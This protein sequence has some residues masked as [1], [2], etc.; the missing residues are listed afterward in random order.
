MRKFII[1]LA[2]V[3]AV[4]VAA[5]LAA[6]RLIDLTP[7]KHRVAERAAA[8]AGRDIT[9][10]GDLRFSLIPTTGAVA[11]DVRVATIDGGEN[12][13][14]RVKAV[15]VQ[16]AFWPLLAG[17]IDVRRITLDGPVAHLEILPDG[18]RSWD[19]QPRVRA[20]DPEAPA[21]DT[22]SAANTPRPSVG[23]TPSIHVGAVEIED[24][25]VVL[26]DRRSGTSERVEEIRAT[27]RSESA[28]GPIASRGQ[29][30]AR[31]VRATY[32]LAIGGFASEAP[33][34]VDLVLAADEGALR[35]ELRGEVE[36]MRS[37][38]RF[39]GHVEVEGDLLVTALQMVTSAAMPGFLAQ[40]FSL[41][42]P[43]EASTT[44]VSA[45]P[46][47]LRF[48]ETSG[49][50]AL[51]VTSGEKPAATLRMALGRIDLDAWLAMPMTNPAI[52]PATAAGP[53]ATAPSE[54]GGAP[55]VASTLGAG[56]GKATNGSGMTAELIL[57]AEAIAYRQGVIAQP[58]VEAR[59]ADGEVQV[60]SLSAKLPGGG[61]LDLSGTLATNVAPPRFRGDVRAEAADLRALLLWLG[62]DPG[63]VPAGHLRALSLKGSIAAEPDSVEMRVLE[64][65]LDGSRITG[66]LSAS[67]HPSPRLFADLAV[68]RL[69]LDPY[70][71]SFPSGREQRTATA[72]SPLSTTP[73]ASPETASGAGVP[74]DSQADALAANVKLLLGTVLFQGETARDVMIDGALGNGSI[75]L[76]EV[77]VA[78]FAGASASAAGRLLAGETTPTLQDLDLR[79]SVADAHR[80]AR[81][82]GSALPGDARALGA[83]DGAVTLNGPT[84]AL[85]IRGSVRAAAAS[86]A[87]DGRIDPLAPRYQG[88][89][90]VNTADLP[91]LLRVA[92]ID[93][94]PRGPLGLTEVSGLID[95]GPSAVALSEISGR[96]GGVSIAGAA[97]LDGSASRPVLK[98]D[99]TAGPLDVDTFLPAQRQAGSPQ[100]LVPVAWRPA[101]APSPV[102]DRRLVAA[103]LHDRWSREPFELSALTLID[104][105]VAFRAQAV[106]FESN[107][108]DDAS[109]TAGLTDG[110]LTVSRLTG[111][112]WG[113]PLRASG[114]IDAT[115]E[116]VIDLAFNVDGADGRN[117][118]ISRLPGVVTVDTRLRSRGRSVAGLVSG[119]EGDGR[120]DVR[121]AVVGADLSSPGIIGRVVSPLFAGIGQLTS[122]LVPFIGPPARGPALADAST[123]F[124]V[125]NG[126]VR[127]PD[128]RFSAPVVSGTATGTIDL[129]AWTVDLQGRAALPQ[130]VVGQLLSSLKQ[131]PGS[132][133]FSVRGSLDD[134]RVVVDAAALQGL[135]IPGLDAI[136]RQRGLG[137]LLDRALPR[138]S[139][140]PP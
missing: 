74:E 90:T 123:S 33:V 73:S 28:G 39:R 79:F 108:L 82:V 126:L 101:P 36:T 134:P 91:R 84:T 98:A 7:W 23:A 95:A 58:A 128:L 51:H 20:A 89:L 10:E 94:R 17:R 4:V 14:L 9:V 97:A 1:G 106:S 121:D 47:F 136:G 77:R 56:T 46:L 16:L 52:A 30:R 93:Y 8:L 72:G 29:V 119:L 103:A 13:L 5:A 130:S 109:L 104:A 115:A 113:G 63:T 3:V 24:G 107:T 57:T 67:G 102:F 70:L 59:L 40:P 80:L 37:D 131:A 65:R 92:E 133:G 21:T 34:P 124:S 110:V 18:R 71:E 49:R 81:A 60:R 87:V 45:D 111:R 12:D 61:D 120:L 11:E 100:G 125:R 114:R 35:A 53:P 76:R 135:R 38:P 140:T 68:D 139:R 69:N 62:L 138:P 41:D 86:L 6:P 50:G 43:L 26:V 66:T 118:R 32:Q 132:I 105:D 54:E 78:D 117:V 75:D 48:G 85:A 83:V 64:A 2:A 42:A 127:L 22:G 44:R 96:L 99:L 55:A 25:T 88:R 112:L 19:L 116:P 137:N 122:L 27:L 129:P 31:G 15:D